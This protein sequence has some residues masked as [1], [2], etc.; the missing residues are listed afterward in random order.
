MARNAEL[1]GQGLRL[2]EIRGRLGLTR[3][4]FAARL[5]LRCGTLKGA[6]N[7]TQKLGTRTMRDAEQMIAQG[8]HAVE[9]SGPCEEERAVSQAYAHY[10]GTHSRSKPVL[11]PGVGIE[12]VLQ[13]SRSESM[14]A[15]ATA[16]AMAT[17]ISEEEALAEVI[18]V[19]LSNR[20]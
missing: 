16:L 15:A 9:A 4:Q 10:G 6:E 13:M 11:P 2:R 7:G 18:R 20:G 3:E 19:A 14:R 17:G 1:E 12:E 5:G 8:S